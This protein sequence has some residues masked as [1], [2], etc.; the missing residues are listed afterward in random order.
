VRRARQRSIAA[1]SLVALAGL[2]PATARAFH[3]GNLFDKPPGA[4]GGGGLFYTGAPRDKGWDCTA[5]HQGPPGK[6]QI[7]LRADPPDLLQTFRYTPGQTYT[8]DVTM[9]G[10][11]AGLGSPLS[12]F[13]A[14]A[15]SIV[16]PK[17]APVGSMSGFAAEEFYSGWP[18]T[19]VSGGQRVG[20]T[21]WSF[22][23][24]AGEA[25]AGPVSIFVAA[26]DGNGADSP[27]DQTLTD[28]FGDDVF[29]G[30]VSLEEGGATASA[31]PPRAPARLGA[32][33]CVAG[34]A[35]IGASRRRARTPARRGEGQARGR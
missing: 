10:E 22:Q 12:N 35:A 6:I 8:F 4:G 13:N 24:I 21:S 33:A 2:A 16:D 29:V 19:I 23:W 5:C 17:G 1:L 30:T 7:R 26:V 14:L 20:A 27:P 28:P 11:S 34:L 25:G 18:T 15:V 32:L 31:A 9:E 3:A